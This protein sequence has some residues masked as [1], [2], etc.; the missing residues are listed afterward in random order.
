MDEN[1]ITDLA[2][3]V[4]QSSERD[5]RPPFA[6]GQAFTPIGLDFTRLPDDLTVEEWI[7]F[8]QPLVKA[9]QGTQWGTGD[10]TIH[11]GK[12]YGQ[13][14]DVQE[15]ATGLD[16]QTLADY[17]YVAL[18]FDFS[19]RNDNVAWS[20]H[21]ALAPLMKIDRAKALEY[22]ARAEAERWTVAHAR[23]QVQAAMRQE[24][25]PPTRQRRPANKGEIRSISI[26]ATSPTLAAAT[27]RRKCSQQFVEE[28]REALV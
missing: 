3:V 23:A 28:L 21:R 27:I 14:Y 25:A 6:I 9:K 26:S 22:L 7:A 15:A 17:T 5:K 16:R 18:A 24:S 19:L 10:W 13:T 11:I 1:R 20:V 8:A 12:R 2:Q 4:P